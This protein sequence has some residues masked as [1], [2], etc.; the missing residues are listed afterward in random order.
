MRLATVAISEASWHFILL[1]SMEGVGEGGL[2]LKKN[3]HTSV[4][5]ALAGAEAGKSLGVQG[6]S[7]LQS[8]FEASQDLRVRSCLP[9]TPK[10]KNQDHS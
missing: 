1:V 6:Q 10:T 8:K 2:N 3:R 7:G 4:T 5:L 9:H